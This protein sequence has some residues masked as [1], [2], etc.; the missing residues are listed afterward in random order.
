M[1]ELFIS[2]SEAAALAAK[3][4]RVEI[5]SAY[6][7]TPNTG[8]IGALTEL[9]E[10]GQM[11][12]TSVNVDGEHSAAS[13]CA[14]ASSAGARAF[15][16]TCGQGMAFMHEVLWMAS[17]M[18]LP[19]VVAVTSRGIGSPQTIVSDF[20]D[21]MSERDSSFLQYY[22]ENVQE[23]ID[24]II[25][26]YK[27]GEHE[28]VLLPSFVSLEAFRMTHTYEPVDI[29]D[30]EK[31]DAFLPAYNPKHAFYDTN[32]PVLQGTGAVYEFTYRKFEQHNALIKAKS[33][34]KEACKEFEEIFGRKY[35][36]VDAYK[37]EDAEVVIVSMGCISA[38]ARHLVN[39][40]REKGIALGAL[41]VRVFRP[42]PDEEIQEA[43]S[44]AKKVIVIDRFNSPGSHGVLYNEVKSALY[45]YKPA[46]TSYIVGHIDVH[47]ED[48]QN[49]VDKVLATDN[50]FEEWYNVQQPMVD[51][52][53]GEFW[54][55]LCGLE[56]YK[57]LKK[58]EKVERK[59]V[60]NTT[61]FMPKGL[62]LCSGCTALLVCRKVLETM[63][64]ETVVPYATS[65]VMAATSSI[66]Q[67]GWQVPAG[68]YCFTNVASA[69]SGIKVA[70]EKKEKDYN[71]VAIG[72][73]GGIADIGLQAL[74]GAAERG[75]NITYV[76]YDN[77]AYMNTGAQR[78]STT[79]YLAM[80]KTSIMGKKVKKK[81]ISRIMEAHG[82][83][84]ATALPCFLGD[85]EKKIKRAKEV[86]GPAFLH[87]LAPCPTGWM[88]DTALGIEVA[89]LAYETG[90]WILYESENG[91]RTISKIPKERKPVEE[92]LKLQGRFSHLTDEQIKEI[93]ND[94]DA[95]F[96]EMTS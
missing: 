55:G 71:V 49:M 86:N 63:G 24:S 34:I 85:M 36:L 37:V 93:Q 84:V 20:S 78:S 41:K 1:S 88:F 90:S 35:G 10:S 54:E 96:N 95:H 67:S 89:R 66:V 12:A 45:D 50:G 17:G 57:K 2:S 8:V 58:G 42:F 6:P 14:G 23:V 46:I 11:D 51:L 69:A 13:V 32:Y 73:D 3:L 53:P 52:I 29:P 94:V 64:K 56:N 16:A 21:I 7:I 31:V 47:S 44:K 83:Y 18:A 77:E 30:Q 79:S 92:Y 27:I 81:D 80:T 87:I 38:V 33:I 39:E 4:S 68:H 61:D 72:G 91:K 40:Y 9:I 74:S 65:C 59:D 60:Q 26:A 15:T 48:M 5:V 62:N 22:S 19:L 82:I 75:H 25:M 70:L 43:L 28:D 76:C